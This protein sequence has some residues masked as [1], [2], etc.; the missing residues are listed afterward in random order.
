MALLPQTPEQLINE[1]RRKMAM[2]LLEQNEQMPQGQ[3]VGSV[4]V[5]PSW[6]QY[7]AKGLNQYNARK[8]MDNVD[9]AEAEMQRKKQ[10]ALAELLKGNAPQQITEQTQQE[11][12]PA[13]TP[14]QQDRF[15]SPLPNVQRQP[16]IESIQTTRTETPDELQQ[17]QRAKLYE[18]ISQYGADPALQM[19]MGDL[20]YQR[21][22]GLQEE[23]LAAEREFRSSE[24]EANREQRMQELLMRMEDS[25]LSR[26]QQME[27]RREL[28]QMQIEAR[29]E[30]A[31][32]TAANRPEKMVT[33][34][35]PEGMPVMVPQSQAVGQT[36][37]TPQLAA[38]EKAKATSKAG[39][40][41]VNE[42]VNQLGNAYNTL[43]TNKGITSTEGGL[44][45]N[46][47]AAA[48]TTAAGQFL[49]RIG[50]TENQKARDMI[51][52]TR[53]LMLNAI[54][55]ATGM[56]AQQMNSNAEMQLYLNAA[57]NPELGLEANLAALQNLDKLYGLGMFEG[58]S[59]KTEPNRGLPSASDIDA[60]LARRGKK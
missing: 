20:N 35:G 1:R 14:E 8:E 45:E 42:I 58:G 47:G 30:I 12:M 9:K 19:V 51:A 27:A 36:P 21:D 3:M 59:P 24:A 31:G 44:I 5:A 11:V 52:Q 56:S 18:A 41:Q 26:E 4:F 40:E 57:T 39:K 48:S 28:A 13:Y 49:G 17:R 37:Y 54:K 15:G 50:G 46:L 6:T 25:R 22:L 29:R 38:Q 55:N 23:R 53:P 16:V 43:K 60:E 34:L 33:I 7:L 32:I 10:E 2:R